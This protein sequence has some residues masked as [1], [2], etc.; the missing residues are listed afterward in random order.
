MSSYAVLW[1]EPWR[2]IQP[3]KLEL[4]PGGLRFEGSRRGR[5]ADVH[6]LGYRSAVLEGVSVWHAGSPYYSET[7][8]AKAAFHR[9]EDRILARKDAV[10]RLLL[11][12]PFVA[13]LNARYKWFELPHSYVPPQFDERHTDD[14][15]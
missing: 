4:D 12:M 13:A 2:D 3:G 1:S 14:G 15:V 8:P 10:K 11:S 6:R 7:S 5:E 9:R